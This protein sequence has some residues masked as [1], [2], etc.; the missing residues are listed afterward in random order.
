[1]AIQATTTT[2]PFGAI[3]IFSTISKLETVWTSLV[4]WNRRRKTVAAL[5]ALSDHELNDIGLHRSNIDEM[6]ARFATQR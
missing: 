5:N 2:A 1:M 3:T 6:A 4:E